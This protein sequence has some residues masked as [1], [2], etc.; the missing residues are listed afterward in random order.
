MK[1]ELYREP[2]KFHLNQC[3][4]TITD[5]GKLSLEPDEMISFR[6]ASGRECDFVAK[7]WGFYPLSSPNSRMKREGFKVALV[8]NYNGKIQINVIEKDKLDIFET[9]L[10]SH[11][12]IPRVICW[13]DEI[14]PVQLD[15][16]EGV[17]RGKV[18]NES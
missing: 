9:Y 8:K 1:L 16:I 6:T 17:L 15:S 3:D 4:T 12:V 13:L 5:Y 2:R 14:T 11:S 7:E 10:N 18:N